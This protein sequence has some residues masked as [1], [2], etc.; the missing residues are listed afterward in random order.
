MQM[1]GQAD[2]KYFERCYNKIGYILCLS[3]DIGKLITWND[4]TATCQSYNNISIPLDVANRSVQD[5]LIL[6]K[7]DI[8]NPL[9]NIGNWIDISS[10]PIDA[11]L[12]YHWFDG[13]TDAGGKR[14]QC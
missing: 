13:Q 2:S 3:T 10:V 5:A 8:G 7:N 12:A 1:S 6:F 14:V 4:F 9:E 11:P